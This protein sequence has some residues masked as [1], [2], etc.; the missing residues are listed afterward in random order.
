MSSEAGASLQR[1]YERRKAAR[2]KRVRERF[3]RAGGFLLAITPEAQTTEAFAKGAA[4]ERRLAKLLE[5]KC[6]DVLFLHNRQR[7]TRARD[8]DI[9]HIAIAPSGVHV[10][11]AKNYEDAKV[12]VIHEGGLFSE[13]REILKVRGRD[14]TNLV[15]S[16]TRTHEAVEQALVGFAEVEVFGSFAF[17][18]AD[19]P[20]LRDL[21][22]DGF[23]VRG[24]HGTRRALQEGGPLDATRRQQIW[25]HL[26]RALP[27]AT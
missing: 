13:R 24:R 7:G 21:T 23:P 18:G 2:E 6:P 19:L 8:G 26:A 5:D 20:L 27:P 22:V 17:I 25:E 10:I 4:G 15:T 3:P 11:D 9:D 12:D 1:E 14:R 16:L